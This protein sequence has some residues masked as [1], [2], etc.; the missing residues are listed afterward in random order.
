MKTVKKLSLILA[1]S[2]V[3]VMCLMLNA[4]AEDL[5]YG[6][7]TYTVLEDDT[8]KITD[9]NGSEKDIV[10]P[11]EIDGKAVTVIGELA[12]VENKEISSVVIPDSVTSVEKRAFA[13]CENLLEVTFG[14]SLTTIGH[15]AFGYTALFSIELPD[16]VTEIGDFAFAYIRSLRYADLGENVKYIGA[17]AFNLCDTLESGIRLYN[18]EYIGSY[19][20]ASCIGIKSVSVSEKLS[21]I[22]RD[23]FPEE[24]GF[25]L[26]YAGSEE[27]F[28]QIEFEEGNGVGI[29]RE[30]NHV[31]EFGEYSSD[32]NATTSCDG[33]KSAVCLNGCEFRDKIRDKGTKL[34]HVVQLTKV[35][36][37]QTTTEITLSWD[38]ATGA[39]TYKIYYKDGSN[40]KKCATTSATNHT[41]KNL[42]PGAKYI[43]SVQAGRILGTSQEWPSGR[44]ICETATKS[45]PITTAAATQTT[46]TIK[47]TWSASEGATGYRIFYQSGGKWKTTVSSTSATSHTFKNLKPGAKYTFA[48][49]PYVKNGTA[50]VWGDY[51]ELSTATKS[52][53]ISKLT[54]TQS[55]S[56]IKLSWS[57]S[58]G[59]TGYRIFYQSGGKW[60]VTVSSTAATSHTFKNLNA[61]AKFTFA[62]Q[63]YVKSGNAVIWSDYKTYTAATLP[64]APKVTASS[65]LGGQAVVSWNAVS[66]AEGYRLYYKV[67]NGSYKLYKTYSK[68]QT[69]TFNNLTKGAKYTFVVRAGKKTSGGNIFS[70]YTP[71]STTIAYKITRYQK[72]FESGKF[73][74]QVNDPDLGVVAMALNGNKMYVESSMEGMSIK[75]IFRG[76]KKSLSH[77]NGTWYMVMD[78]LKK[79]TI[80]PDDIMG[81]DGDISEGFKD[82]GE[83]I[84]YKTTYETINGKRYEVESGKD[85]QGVTYKYYFNGDT[86]VRSQEILADGTVETTDINKITSSVP[87]G[88]FEIPSDYSL[89]DISWI[90]SGLDD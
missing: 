26:Y 21:Y 51:I 4:A 62:V 34:E 18:A 39:N 82:D 31:H 19:A 59:A 13:W 53:A 28:N 23:A 86:L 25:C 41:F 35:T 33:S 90:L 5:V 80:M 88:L 15:T 16:T 63:P 74:M 22:G 67:N 87:N 83:K 20:F 10:L 27:Q 84:T 17:N 75:L 44:A 70:A 2:F 66:G 8:V 61:G 40:W 52:D 11:S 60:K 50:V 12:F 3:A 38:A 37:T 81:D 72:V 45:A 9:Y 56:A 47:L 73:Y 79:Y 55:E 71:V 64:A 68:A 46:S 85:S 78:S 42:K 36:A 6:D 77:P 30:Y 48:I 32:N 43:F 76:D 14:N 58:S 69:L 65:T 7:Y 49:Q 24:P 29:C 57:V 89:M 54:A 1:L